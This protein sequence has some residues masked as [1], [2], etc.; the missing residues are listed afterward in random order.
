MLES[1]LVIT[2]FKSL[3]II[4]FTKTPYYYVIEVTWKKIDICKIIL[5]SAKELLI[6]IISSNLTVDLFEF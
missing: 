2:C 5:I 1:L 3:S 4:P 6:F